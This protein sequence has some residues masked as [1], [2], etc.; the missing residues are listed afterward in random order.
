MRT[1]EDVERYLRESDI[2]FQDHGDG[3]FVVSDHE[4]GV[5]NLA[6]KVEG[7][8]VV[9]RLRAGDVPEP[10]APGREKLFEDLL[11]LNGQ[12]LL[13]SAF[14]LGD[15]GVY[16]SAAIPLENLDLNELRAVVEDMGLAVS[17]H[18]PGLHLHAGN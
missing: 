1:T 15:D 17:Q 2:T 14:S 8:V 10:G 6:I 18:L 13:H 7:P 9:F 12:G 4:T 16:L 3:L 11:R 5:R